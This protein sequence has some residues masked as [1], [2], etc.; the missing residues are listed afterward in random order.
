MYCNFNPDSGYDCDLIGRCS[1]E[2][3]V[4]VVE[5]ARRESQHFLHNT[6]IIVSQ[7]DEMR[8]LS[9]DLVSQVS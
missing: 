2:G 4:G 8:Q 6:D 7:R 5:L 1:N 3:D 9:K